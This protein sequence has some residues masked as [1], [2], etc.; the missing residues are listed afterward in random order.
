MHKRSLEL[1][2]RTSEIKVKVRN[3]SWNDYLQK[4]RRAIQNLL[5]RK[6]LKR[7]AT[8]FVYILH[9]KQF[10]NSDHTFDGRILTSAEDSSLIKTVRI[11]L[12]INL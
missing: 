1:E 9:Y 11:I 6:M 10:F 2:K 7:N 8:L 5:G 4:T 12:A 3:I